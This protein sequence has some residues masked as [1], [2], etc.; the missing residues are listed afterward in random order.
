MIGLSKSRGALS[1]PNPEENWAVFKNVHDPIIE[2][3]VWE[4]V[5]QR[6]GKTKRRPP[7][8]ENGPKHLLADYLYCA[9]CGCKL[10]Y[11]V[12]SINH[13]R[14]FSCSNY[15]KDY[16]G[17]CPT[18]HYV[19]ADSL[20]QVLL[21]EFRRMASLLVRDE[22]AFAE[23]L[24]QKTG[25]LHRQERSYANAELQKA[26]CRME[27]LTRLYERLYE[28]N[29]SGKVTD[30]WFL[31]LS[32]KYEVE[33]MDLK[34][35]TARLRQQLAEAD[36]AEQDQQRFLRAVRKFLEMDTLTAPL[37]SELVEKI[38][39]HET[40]GTGRN[41]TQRIEICYRF[42]GY[43]DIPEAPQS[44]IYQEHIRQGVEQAFYTA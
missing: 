18:R 25:Q 44:P 17:T 37:L 33:R 40:E 42:V 13:I 39:I 5:Q 11:H 4:Q 43:L 34:T 38:I 27:D 16:R 32:H 3:E 30:E 2:R 7:K 1:I 9:D 22:D 21:L 12:N 41:R 14:F 28:D 29:V 24:A 20:E 26:L 10:W 6:I 15:S 35:K 23:L 36:S 31:Q 8:A 19:R